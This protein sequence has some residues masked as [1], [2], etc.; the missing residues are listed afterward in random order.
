MQKI[1]N[2]MTPKKDLLYT[3]CTPWGRIA[4]APRLVLPAL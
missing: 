2:I 1:M 3:L 4:V